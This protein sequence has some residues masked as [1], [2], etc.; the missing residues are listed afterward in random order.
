M[1]W[2]RMASPKELVLALIA[3]LAPYASAGSSAVVS[4]QGPGGPIPDGPCPPFQCDMSVPFNV[5][6]YWS[7]L[8]SPV[9]VSTH[10]DRVTAVVIRGLKH[11]FRG[12]LHVYLENPA[13]ERFNIIVRP[14]YNGGPYSFGDSG[15]YLDGIYTIVESGGAN[16]QQGNSNIVGATYNQHCFNPGGGTWTTLLFPIAN[17]PLES[18]SGGPGT[19][20]LHLRDWAGIYTGSIVGWR[21]IGEYDG[22]ESAFC[23]GDNVSG[24]V[25]C[26]CAAGAPGSGCAN[27]SGV[28]AVLSVTGSASVAANDL[29]LVCSGMLPGSASIFLQGTAA[30]NGGL[31]QHS[32]GTDGLDCLGGW[33]LRVDRR[34][35]LGSVARVSDIARQGGIP[36]AGAL[37]RYQVFYRNAANYCTP[38]HWN[39]SNA[40]KIWWTP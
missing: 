9:T 17:L 37:R 38:A 13:G 20:K 15:E 4:S 24:A 22:E 36:S 23:F 32:A 11:T 16:L 8:I 35:T 2:N 26:P 28:G 31:G 30:L 21:L 27:S 19:W 14:G 3:A 34:G 10:V 5:V 7:A 29:Q 1:N 18:I 40:V 39:T 12:D 25:T 6:P 33:L